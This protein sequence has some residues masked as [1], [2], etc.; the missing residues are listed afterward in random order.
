M[1]KFVLYRGLLYQKPF[2][3][4]TKTFVVSDF[5]A[6]IFYCLQLAADKERQLSLTPSRTLFALTMSCF[7]ADNARF[8]EDLLNIARTTL[9]SKILSQ[10]K[11]YFSKLAVDAVLRLKGSGNLSAIQII[12]KTGGTL[13]DSFLDEG[14]NKK[15]VL[16]SPFTVPNWQYVFIYCCNHGKFIN[17][18]LS[19]TRRKVR[20]IPNVYFYT[21]LA[22][23]RPL[24]C[25]GQ[26]Q[27][28]TL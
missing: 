2:Y 6:L 14:I 25:I 12:K 17:G 24:L 7:S 8:Q 1:G 26:C 19:C 13:E 10:H 11:E 4:K 16:F 22:L 21:G 28:N 23:G 5:V 9:S 27:I 18:S 3:S 15:N 20:N